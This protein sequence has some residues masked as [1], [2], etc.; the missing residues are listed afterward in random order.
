MTT[1]WFRSDDSDASP[2]G[3][4]AVHA[5]GTT[6]TFMELDLI[7]RL[8][9]S[10]FKW[11]MD[12]VENLCTHRT[13]GNLPTA[14]WFQSCALGQSNVADPLSCLLSQNKPTNHQHDAEEYVRFAANST[15]PAALTTRKVEAALVLDEELKALREAMKT[16]RFEKCKVYAPAAVELCVIGQLILWGTRIIL[17]SKLRPQAISLAHKGHLGIVGTKAEFGKQGMVPWYW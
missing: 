10:C 16:G 3:F 1:R 14:L 6:H 13:L 11:S 5:K 17:P 7:W 4:G 8:I 12:L 2:L 15:T 9:T